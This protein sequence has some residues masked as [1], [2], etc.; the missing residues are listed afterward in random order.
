MTL[1]FSHLGI[2]VSDLERSVRFYRDA[3][4]FEPVQ[5]HRV[6]AE[7]AVLMELDDV[8]LRSCFVRRDGVSIELLHFDEPGHRG[9][10]TRRPMNQLGLTHLSFRV[11]DVDVAAQAVARAG[12]TVHTSTR[13][14]FGSGPQ[15]LDFV[16]CTDPDGVRIELMRLPG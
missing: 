10:P 7:F 6:G 9:D 5:E 8:A 4:G 15:T 3:L 16:Y 14:T 2:C 12:G 13:T 1:T 11:D